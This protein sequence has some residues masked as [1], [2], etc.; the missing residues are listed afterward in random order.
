M[1]AGSSDAPPGGAADASGTA[2]EGAAA[3]AAAVATTG[4]G[5][6]FTAAPAVS[7]SAPS[8]TTT[9]AGSSPLVISQSSPIHGPTVTGRISTV[10]SLPTTQT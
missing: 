8:T 2:F 6:G 7:V 5:R 1:R 4:S 9:L 3:E 10:F